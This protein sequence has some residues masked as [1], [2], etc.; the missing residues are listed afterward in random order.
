MNKTWLLVGVIVVLGAVTMIIVGN[1]DSRRNPAPPTAQPVVQTPV[2]SH[3]HPHPHEENRIPAYLEQAPSR[4][5]LG[6]TLEPAK[7]TGLVRDAYSAVR[8]IP[9]TIAQLPCYC[10]CDRGAGHKSLYS[11]FEDAHA[12]HCAVCVNEALLALKLEKEQKLT[13]AQ[14]RDRI[15]QEYGQEQH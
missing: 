10:H 7:F 5:S 3:S 15:V 13:A 1:S 4:A 9:Q 14:I 11:C 12:S 2:D 8:E 6:P